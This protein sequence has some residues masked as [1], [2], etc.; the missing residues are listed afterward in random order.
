MQGKDAPCQRVKKRN[1]KLSCEI[2]VTLYRVKSRRRAVK[3]YVERRRLGA[4]LRGSHSRYVERP[5][6]AAG[7]PTFRSRS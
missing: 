3:R 1:A 7:L 5:A 2:R 6:A 4:Y